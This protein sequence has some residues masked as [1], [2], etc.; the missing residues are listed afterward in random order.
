MF[1]LAFTDGTFWATAGYTFLRIAIGFFSGLIAGLLLAA[2]AGRFRV[3]ET[4]LYPYMITVKSIPVASF[5]ILALIWLTASKL[6]AFVSFLM[7]LPV[8]YTNVLTG[9]R[10]AD[11]KLLE[12][13]YVFR[14]PF[15]RRISRVW[16]PQLRAQI[17][18][19]CRIALGLAWKSGVAAELIGYPSGSIGEQL[20]YA[21]VYFN[22][23]DLFAWTAFIVLFSLA[24]EK[25]FLFALGRLTA[26]KEGI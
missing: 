8:V 23:V 7:V 25:L 4:L 5:V 15:F 26:G 21:K 16:L 17:I 22:T 24:F 6:A 20:Y 13:A 3:I 14:V 9:I 11:V 12:M 18:S 2:L 1:A 10:S 19:A